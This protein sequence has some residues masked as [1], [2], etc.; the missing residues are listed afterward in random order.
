MFSFLRHY[1]IPEVIVNAISSLYNNSKTAV[2]VDGN[3]SDPFQVTTG[4]LQG[5]V[6]APFLFIVL[7]D[8]LMTKATE[9]TD[10]GVVTHP[11][12]SSR[13]PAKIL[14]D[15]DF[16]DDIAFAGVIYPFCTGSTYQN[17]CCSRTAWPHHQ[18]SQDRVYDYQLQFSIAIG[19]PIK[20]ELNFKYLGS[21]M[22][23]SVS[24]NTRRRALAWVA[25]LEVGSDLEKPINVHLHQNQAF[26][27]HLCDSASLWM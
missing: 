13:H 17:S 27:H 19:Q 12:Q 1:G 23:S 4:V 21:M 9:D 25:F 8:Y 11:R 15:L 22:A 2:M 20:H 18:C 24:D 14:N 26:Q 5:D 10:S 7:I 3:I 6:L 16:A